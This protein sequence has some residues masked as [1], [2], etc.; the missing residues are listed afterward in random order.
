MSNIED[1]VMKKYEHIFQLKLPIELDKDFL[2]LLIQTKTNIVEYD[3]TEDDA[4]VRNELILERIGFSFKKQ[5]IENI[6]QKL[7]DMTDEDIEKLVLEK[8]VIEIKET[9]ET[10]SELLYNA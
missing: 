6:Q 8:N 10:T 9:K 2:G 1:K 5:L 4:K 7:L 3:R